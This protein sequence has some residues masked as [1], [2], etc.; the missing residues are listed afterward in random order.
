MSSSRV[1]IG[2]DLGTTFSCVA[3]WKDGR[4]PR[5]FRRRLGASASGFAG[6]AHG[7]DATVGGTWA[8]SSRG[9]AHRRH[10]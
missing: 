7:I 5:I 10:W 1:A 3:V 8:D 9:K 6:Q 4:S 2:I